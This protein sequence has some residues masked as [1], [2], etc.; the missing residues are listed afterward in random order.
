MPTTNRPR[1][2]RLLHLLAVACVGISTPLAAQNGR[3]AVL[4]TGSSSGI[5]LK[6]TE[7]LAAN[8]YFVYAGARSAEDLAMLD[9]M[10]N[11]ESIRLDVTDQDEID[12]AVATVTSAGRGLYGLV[13]NA[14]VAVI[15]PLIE[16]DEEDFDFQMDAN[17]YGPYR[18]TK[19]FAPLII[20]SRGRISTT[21]SLSGILSGA[22]S[23]P[24][25]MSKH[26]VEAFTDALAEEMIGF[27]VS[28]S[29]VEPGNYS[30]DIFASMRERSEAVGATA[31]G[32]RYAEMME[33]I[34]SMPVDR[35][36]YPEPDDVA[37]AVLSFMS[38]ADPKR[39]Y[40]V[41]PNQNEAGLTIRQVLTELV[42]LNE[43]HQY[44]YDRDDLVRML[45]EALA[46][47]GR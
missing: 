30:S 4:V 33:R 28:V 47:S 37:E 10:D 6:I 5:G 14:G 27:G 2:V 23:G 19:A 25:S 36:Q 18:V 16:V 41:V 20:E 31:S 22:L 1:F 35:S 11:V 3:P 42:Q 43:D 45:D 39:R 17:V 12:A 21:G 9:A 34:L 8:G 46:A 29:V 13:N 24:Y 44:S 32:S 15:A 7:V 40:L 38:D 26:A